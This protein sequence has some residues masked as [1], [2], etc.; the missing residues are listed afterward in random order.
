MNP[1]EWSELVK[2]KESV[3]GGVSSICTK[4]LE[5]FTE[6]LVK[7]WRGKGNPPPSPNVPL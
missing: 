1:D 4:D 7:S 6:L 2:L 3:D 5:R